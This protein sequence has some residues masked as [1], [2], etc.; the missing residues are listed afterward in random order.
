VKKAI[1]FHASFEM[2]VSSRL[3]FKRKLEE[4]R[5]SWSRVHGANR[6]V[7]SGNLERRH[8]DTE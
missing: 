6:R 1:Y 2:S 7:S 4:R 3:L 5:T 8:S